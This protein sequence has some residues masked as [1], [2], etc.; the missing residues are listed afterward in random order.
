MRRILRPTALTCT[1]IALL[2]AASARAQ[3]LPDAQQVAAL[4]DKQCVRLLRMLGE[5][6]A[7]AP[8]SVKQAVRALDG[9]AG[10]CETLSGL[11]GDVQPGSLSVDA[12]Q[13]LA[14]AL[15]R[16]GVEMTAVDITGVPNNPPAALAGGSDE[17]VTTTETVTED[18]ARSSDEDFV[19]ATP[20]SGMSDVEKALVVGAGALVVGA[21][22]SQNRQVVNSTPDRVVVEQQDGELQVLKDDNALLRQPGSEVETETFGDGSS[23]TV[24]TRPDGTRIMTIRDAELRVVRRT[25]TAPNGV[26]TVLIDDTQAVQPVDVSTLPAEVEETRIDVNDDAALR[27]ALAVQG[28]AGRAFSLAQVR[29]IDRVR[30]LAPAIS[31]DNITF[32][33]AR[34]RSGRPRR[35]SFRCWGRRLPMRLR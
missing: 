8:K 21:I 29:D 1:G 28:D 11:W 9:P 34:P 13:L 30:K 25:S 32:E 22:I 7:T 19:A 16:S 26:E 14:A 4:D 31:V 3:T 23:R 33:T 2:L 24:V 12:A 6:K 18:T 35:S 5:D 27:A 20:K 17:A 10:S 15:K